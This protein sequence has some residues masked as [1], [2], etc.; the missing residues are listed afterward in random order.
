MVKGQLTKAL[1]NVD[2]TY[3]EL[4]QIVNEIAKPYIEE[5]DELINQVS[6]NVNDL[7][8]DYLR[9]TMVKLSL[10]SYSF[11]E[12]KEKSV[13]KAE[14]SEALRKEKY[15][16]KF[17]GSDGTVAFKEN[18]ALI[19]TTEEI[20][21]EA[22]YNLLSSLFKTKL[23]EIHRVVD[24]IKTVIMSRNAEEKMSKDNWD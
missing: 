23:D 6:Y 19:E 21:V 22:I 11:S 18:N 17:N 24:V 13:L 3:M 15:A 20:L 16:I 10:K 8:N 7:T 14:C 5:V 2:A 12:I 9:M 1:E 4:V